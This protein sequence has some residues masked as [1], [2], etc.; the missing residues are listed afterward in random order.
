MRKIVFHEDFV[1]GDHVEESTNRSFGF[2]V[3]GAFALISLALVW[4]G[5]RS[6]WWLFGIGAAFIAA[7]LSCPSLLAYPNRLWIRLG[8]LLFHVVNPVVMAILYYL[9]MVPIG[10]IMR[11]LRKDPL[12]LK[13]DQSAPTYW[14]KRQP[15]SLHSRGMRDQF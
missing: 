6:G 1:R 4:Y 5:V 14:V 3:G 9:C 13:L 8:M 11:L 2:V 10:L 15:P 7:A 12:K